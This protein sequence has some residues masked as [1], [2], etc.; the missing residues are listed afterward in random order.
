MPKSTFDLTEVKKFAD[1]SANWWDYDGPL[2]QLHL[3]NRVRIPYIKGI[4][5]QEKLIKGDQLN[6][7]DILDVGCGG[8]IL[9][10]PLSRLGANITGLDACAENIQIAKDYAKYN[11]YHINYV[12]STIEDFATKRI[13]YDVVC[14]LE[15][16]EHIADINL[17]LESIAQVTKPRG[18]IFVSTINK[19]LKSY[20]QAILIAEYLVKMVPQ[21]GHD[22]NKFVEPSTI[23]D[24]LSRNKCRFIGMK[25]MEFSPL[26]GEWYLD[27]NVDVNYIMALRK[28]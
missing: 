24:I 10:I 9:S 19:T 26:T 6:Q 3:M 25:G 13:L 4:L 17:F 8:G 5:K 11:N 15:I 27:C 22:W 16:V 1:L 2:K 14:A 7:L 23:V 21:G 12:T 18:I 28:L 20:V